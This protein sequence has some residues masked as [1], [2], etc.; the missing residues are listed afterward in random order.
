MPTR[1]ACAGSEVPAPA[2]PRRSGTAR[3]YSPATS[4][5][6]IVL[7]AH[8]TP[9]PC[10]RLSRP[11]WWGVTPTTTTGPPPRPDG[12]S[13]RCACP[14]PPR[15]R[16]APPGRFPRSLTGRSAGSAPSCTPGTSSRATATRRA[17]SAARTE[18]RADKTDLNSNRDRASQQPIAASFGAAV[19]YRGFNHWYRFPYAFLPRY[20]TRPAGGGP[21]LDGRGPLAA[22]RR[23]SGVSAALQLHPAVTAAGDGVLHPARSYGASWRSAA[24][25]DSGS[26]ATVA[27]PAYRQLCKCADRPGRI[28]AP[29]PS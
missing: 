17:A 1:A 8:W 13:G 25:D 27:A 2:P 14:N 23:T 18:K 12:N 9:S 29:E 3:P 16:R 11:P 24:A 19:L 10:G 4:F 15:A 26:L 21:L 5:R 22:Q 28:A 7:R 20:R 6:P